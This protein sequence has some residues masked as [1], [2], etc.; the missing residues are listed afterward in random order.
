MRCVPLLTLALAVP[1]LAA[2][3]VDRSAVQTAREKGVAYLRGSQNAD[4]GWTAPEPL[5]IGALAAVAL[6]ESGVPADDPAVV[7]A[8]D[9]VAAAAKPDG[10]I[11]GEGSIHKNYETA[12]SLM[13]L[14]KAGAGRFAA[15]DRGRP[16]V[17]EGVAVGRGRGVGVERPGLRRGRVRV[18][19][20]AGPLQHAVPRSRR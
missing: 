7:K 18:Q 2:G 11:Y 15:R 3:P 10:G 17:H 5:G 20:P 6:V 9:H 4:G 19:Q 16:G 1:A 13:A 14:E 8:V 12:L